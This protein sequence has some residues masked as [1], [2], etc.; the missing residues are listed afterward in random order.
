MMAEIYMNGEFGPVAVEKMEEG[1]N[2]KELAVFFELEKEIDQ[3]WLQ[4]H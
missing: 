1:L 4:T 2:T 3:K